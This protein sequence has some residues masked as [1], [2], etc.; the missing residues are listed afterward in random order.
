MLSVEHLTVCDSDGKKLLDD[1]SFTLGEGE[2]VAILGPNG[3]GKTTLLRCLFGADKSYSG[4]VVINGHDISQMSDKQRALQIGAVSQ[5]TPADFQLSVRTI[6]ETGRTPHRSMFTYSDPHG[7]A[8][9][10]KS[11]SQLQLDAYLDRDI[12]TL[13]GGEKKRVMI[14]R[15]LVQEPQLLVLDEPCNHLDIQHQLELMQQLKQ[16][17]L[18]CLVS[19]HD[20]SL[21]ARYCDRVLVLK[22]GRLVSQGAPQDVLQPA[23]FADV[24]SVN[25]E[26]YTNPWQQWAFCASPLDSTISR[27]DKNS[28]QGH[29]LATS[30]V[31]TALLASNLVSSEL[32]NQPAINSSNETPF[33]TKDTLGKK[34]A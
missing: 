17:S 20:F 4:K 9:I 26:S 18:S 15:A 3:A 32:I 8:V 2:V 7:Q 16:L 29:S 10:E 31:A 11:V 23:L 25:V 12:K 30:K 21:A 34:H 13:S 22:N 6:I 33:I 19:L 14:C 28:L 1:V 5:E 27:T 24:F